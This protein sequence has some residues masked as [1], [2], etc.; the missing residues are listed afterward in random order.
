[1]I[2]DVIEALVRLAQNQLVQETPESEDKTLAISCAALFKAWK[3]GQYNVGD[4]RTSQGVPYE[5]ILTHDSILNPD[6]TIDVRTLW[7]PYHARVAK[8]A[9]PFIQP[10]GSHDMY[11]AGEYMIWTDGQIYLCLED[12]VYS[13]EEYAQ[14]WE[15]EE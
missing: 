10:T 14:V 6:W 9:L 13:P 7:K 12:T 4:I 3:P 8:W 1:M 15:V 11:K 5:C 2:T